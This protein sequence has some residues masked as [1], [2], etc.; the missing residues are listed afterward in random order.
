MS[1]V[2]V[3]LAAG[4]GKRMKSRLPKV[5]QPILGDP[6]L[7]WVLRALPADTVRALVVVHYGRA[8]VIEAL[9]AWA[10]AGLLPCAVETV[11][12]GEP[13]GTGHAV[14]VCAPALDRAG[15]ERVVILCGDVPLIAPATVADLSAGPPALLAMDLEVPKGYGRVLQNADGTLAGLV[16][17]KDATDAQRAV[18]RVNGGA[19]GLPW[20]ALKPALGRL[21]NRNAQGEYY[22]TDAVADLAAMVPVQVR[23]C[24]EWELAGMNARADQAALQASARDQANR[25][26]MDD[27]VEILDP[28][29]TWIGPRTTLGAD[30]SLEPC[31]RLEGRVDL[32]DGVTVGQG[33]ILKDCRIGPDTR[34]R[35][36]SL[37]EGVVAG[38]ACVIGPFARLREGTVLAESVHIGN[39][40]E[41]KKASLARGAKANHLAYLG[42]ASVGAGTNIGAGVI[43]CNYD[44][45]AKHR[46]EIGAGVFVGSDSQLVAPVTIGD[47]AI[48]GAGS[49]IT[50]DVPAHALALS[51]SSQIMKEDGATRLRA[52]QRAKLG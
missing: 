43:T 16:E 17:E 51:R 22:L 38:A 21:G 47:G 41:T 1:T 35:P 20:A 29:T 24:P 48:I 12:Q 27:G 2:A 5:L 36:Y 26:W 25:R 46:T 37:V 9:A 3:V 11:D 45:V 49:T 30:V 40:V 23:V 8:Q 31:V 34:I 14:Q 7:L 18:Q 52:K 39:F 32:A 6:S 10:A 15:A 28:A 19:Y 33:S 13:L 42:D 44:G 50:E 4:L